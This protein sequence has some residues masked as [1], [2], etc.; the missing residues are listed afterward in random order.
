MPSCWRRSQVFALADQAAS[1][2]LIRKIVA[3]IANS[4][5]KLIPLLDEFDFITRNRNFNLEFFS[6]LRSL[7]KN[8]PVSFVVTSSHELHELCHSSEIAGSAVRFLR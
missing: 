3:R 6:F 4:N 7:P 8:C 1:Y 5:T 2:E